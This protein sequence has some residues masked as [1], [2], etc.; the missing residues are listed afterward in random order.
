M[1]VA[2][3]A[4]IHLGNR[5]MSPARLRTIVRDVNA[6]RPDLVLL[7]GDFTVGHTPGEEANAAASLREPLAGLHARLGTIAVFGNHDN[8]TSPTSIRTALEAA[9]ISVLD[10]R[11]VR[12]G[13]LNII[14]IG[15]A[16]SGHAD[17]RRALAVASKL[18]GVPVVL[19]H[20][21]DIVHELSPDLPLVLTGH[22]HCGQV[23]LPLFGPVLTRSPFQHW[24]RLYDPRLRCGAVRDHGRLI[25]VTAGLGSGSSPIRIGAPPDW[26]L[27]TLRALPTA[28]SR[29]S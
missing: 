18:G 3:L 13:P 17:V 10:N 24:A 21:P 16:F 15:D 27:V 12:R 26:W 14:G 22:T 4:D 5:A 7:A 19:S 2:L 25:I 6:A 20:S 11:A 28:G 9:R 23:V 29:P 1:R 8:W